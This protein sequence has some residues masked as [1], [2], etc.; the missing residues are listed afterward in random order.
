[1]AATLRSTVRRLW[2]AVT[3]PP[4]VGAALL[5][6]SVVPLPDGGSGPGVLAAIGGTT[7]LH[8]V[9]YAALTV[10][11]RARAGRWTAVAGATVGGLLVAA[12]VATAVGFGIELVQ[13]GLPWRTFALVDAAVNAVGAVAGATGLWLRDRLAG[14][15]AD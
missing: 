14:A 8:V 3:A 12:A 13:A 7:T 15:L 9:G 6:G 11:I 2:V 4:V 5:V 10:S 1:V